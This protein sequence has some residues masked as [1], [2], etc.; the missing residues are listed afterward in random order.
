M[1]SLSLV[2]IRSEIEHIFIKSGYDLQSLD[3]PIADTTEKKLCQ[4]V[5]ELNL[6]KKIK[7]A[8]PSDAN[9]VIFHFDFEKELFFQHCLYNLIN[10]YTQHFNIALDFDNIPDFEGNN[11][12]IFMRNILSLTAIGVD[13]WMKNCRTNVT[14]LRDI[15]LFDWDGFILDSAYIANNFSPNGKLKGDCLVH[16]LLKK[17]APIGVDIDWRSHNGSALK[18]SGVTIFRKTKSHDHNTN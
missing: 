12:K 11:D 6:A 10:K 5:T 13:F 14:N 15:D 8:L 1:F 3:A 4:L 9:Q 17:S 2:D 16:H 18:K 7:N